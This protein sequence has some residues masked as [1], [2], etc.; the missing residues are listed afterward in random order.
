VQH[1]MCGIC[2]QPRLF[3]RRQHG[4]AAASG[5]QFTN[6]TN[7]E[8]VVSSRRHGRSIK[9]PGPS[10]AE[11]ELGAVRRCAI[12]DRMIDA[13]ANSPDTRRSNRGRPDRTV[14]LLC[15]CSTE[16]LNEG[17]EQGSPNGKSQRRRGPTPP[18]PAAPAVQTPPGRPLPATQQQD[19]FAAQES[20]RRQ[21]YCCSLSGT[22]VIQS[23]IKNQL[24]LG[25]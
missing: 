19:L 15:T 23:K 3:V 2:H 22:T 4:S 21:P 1:R 10:P 6:P 11:G 16:W 12:A 17:H 18:P 7:P 25:K 20:C 24:Y 8:T 14:C 9:T 5:Q 13:V